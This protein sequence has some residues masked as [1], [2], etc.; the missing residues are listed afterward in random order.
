MFF[1]VCLSVLCIVCLNHAV[2]QETNTELSKKTQMAL[3][4]G[5]N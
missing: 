3:D 5:P 1:L 2:G 4:N